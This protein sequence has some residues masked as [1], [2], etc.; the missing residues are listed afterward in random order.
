MNHRHTILEYITEALPDRRAAFV[1]PSAV[2]AQFWARAAAE[3]ALK[4]ITPARFIA[5]DT[6]KARCLSVNRAGKEA[7]NRA[8]RTLFASNLLRENARKDTPF[9]TDYIN[10][11]YAAFY[12]SFISALSKLLPGLERVLGHC[13]AAGVQEDSYFA[14]LRRIQE[15]Y[16]DFLDAHR[17]YEPAWNRAAFTPSED[18]WLLFFPE[19]AED[20]DEYREE[21]NAL[22]EQGEGGP[23]KIVP[24][25]AI[26]PP[27]YRNQGASEEAIKAILGEYEGRFIQ[28]ASAGE[29]YRWLA[30]TIRRLLDEGGLSLEDIAVSFPG[31]ESERLMQVFRL[32]DLPAGLRHGRPLTEY[33]G[34]RVFAALAACPGTKWSFRS[35]KNLLLDKAFPWKDTLLINALMDFGL[36]YRCVSGFTQGRQEIDVWE[37]TFEYHPV[38]EIADFYKKL[39]NDIL[40]IVNARSFSDLAYKWH[41]FRDCFFDAPAFNPKV[42]A[43]LSQAVKGLNELIQIEARF[44]MLSE[45]N[46]GGGKVFPV[47]QAYI[48]EQTYVYQ[49]GHQ[50]IPI[51]DYKVAAGISPAVHFMINMNQEDAAAVYTGGAFFLREDRKSL[52]GIQ[53]RDISGEFIQAYRFSAAFPVFTMSLKTYNG[54]AIPHRGLSEQLG[55]PLSGDTL[56]FPADPY[57]V[58]A[59]L[60]GEPA[61]HNSLVYPSEIQRLGW[62]ALKTLRKPPCAGDFRTN[63]IE[64][65]DLRFALQKR[66]GT[67][68][69]FR[70]VHGVYPIDREEVLRLTPTDLNKYIACPF[71]WVLQRGLLIREKQ[72]GI[73]TVDQQDLGI[74]YHRILERL[75]MRIKQ[76]RGR[77][78]R[79]DISA[80]KIYLIEET[81]EALA[82][83]RSAEGAFQESIY[84][85]LE[86]RIVAALSDY[87]ESDKAIL[88][89]AEILGAEY[90]LRKIY[91]PTE[92]LLT[93]IAD[94]VLA[95][96]DGGLILTDFKTG[97]LPAKKDIHA[98]ERDAPENVQMAAYIAMLENRHAAADQDGGDKPK[99]VKTAR[100]YSID[101]R[102][103][104]QVVSEKEENEKKHI[105]RTAYEKEVAAVDKVFAAVWE[106]MNRGSY[107]IPKNPKPDICGTCKVSSVCRIPFTGGKPEKTFDREQAKDT[108]GL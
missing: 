13:D 31:A 7:I 44:P 85:M 14:D 50:G 77:F 37:R 17:L 42:N 10:P 78:R 43:I 4:P 34:G 40:A 91:S 58:E 52:L 100:F 68:T 74:L 47:F 16:R 69:S 108:G 55:E 49:S 57:R 48:Q 83:A 53:D 80:Y 76:E 30:L 79:E 89:R 3:A 71:K 67:Q 51:Y 11:A 61:A 102:T 107:Q 23:V 19:L 59:S 96:E 65:R 70:K 45:K 60:E 46:S 22:A 36:R 5:W 54:P 6:F 8:V 103:Y 64:D 41:L 27:H 18:R 75:F 1:F 105:P 56:R 98:E 90:P 63:P 32:Y 38:S 95:Y 33:P 39:K 21:L 24:L 2:P 20:W 28:F 94:L 92:P 88:N 84:A 86:N 82:E 106:A 29:E 26:A 97:L 81:Q 9:L 99:A 62:Q 73:E 66:L 87:L 15:R 35:L 101:K 93:G 25:E 72:T 12:G 104:L